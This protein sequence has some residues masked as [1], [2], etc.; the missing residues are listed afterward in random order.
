MQEKVALFFLPSPIHKERPPM[1]MRLLVIGFVALFSTTAI[2]GE[3]R[4]TG[5]TTV[6]NLIKPHI[7]AVEKITG[8]TLKV[9][10]NATGRG[11][12]EL[13]EGRCDA[14][15]ASEPL[16]IAI[17]SAK[18]LGKDIDPKT[19][20]F[21]LI[22]NDEIVFVVNKSNP[23]TN[24]TMAQIKDIHLGKITNWKE[25]GGK[26]LPIVVFVD[27][28]SGGTRAMIKSVVLGGAEY[29]PSVKPQSSVGKEEEMVGV[30][31]GGFAGVGKGFTVGDAKVS[32]IQTDKFERPLALV[33]IGK[34]S[35]TITGL[36]DALKA[37]TAH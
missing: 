13:V 4:L 20:Q 8:N 35:A 19:L 2:A 32:V 36:I 37:E 21:N 9:I 28:L 18:L 27:V 29:T 23:V 11:L 10:G 34:P 7:A 22:R 26:D 6:V 33:T 30:T 5:S 31:E 24:L 12:F 1:K 25:V 15:M 16:D 3:I 14:S 17:Q